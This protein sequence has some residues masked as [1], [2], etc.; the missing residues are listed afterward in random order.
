MR[1]GFTSYALRH[2][3]TAEPAHASAARMLQHAAEL[4][5]QVVQFCDN[6][7]LHVLPPAELNDV[8]SLAHDLNVGV[9]VGTGGLDADLVR[10][11]VRI[12]MAARSRA[13]RLVP[14]SRDAA[15]IEKLLLALIPE[16]REANV[17]LAVENRLGLGSADLAALLHSIGDPHLGFCV[18]TANSIGLLERPLETVGNLAPLAVQVHLKDYAVDK[19]PV[20]YHVNGR[21]LGEGWLDVPAVLRALGAGWRDLDFL[22]EFWMEPEATASVTCDKEIRWLA[23]SVE[24]ARRYFAQEG[25]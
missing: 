15:L 12:A 18:D 16:L 21:P 13:V 7:P 8:L 19:I 20:G 3:A 25:S 14:Y 24:G 1:L 10:S 2:L 5:L 17:V 23:R 9:E 4:G 11:Y 6:L 22:L